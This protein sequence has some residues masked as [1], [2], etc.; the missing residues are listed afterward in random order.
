MT[1]ALD[2]DH[3]STILLVDDDPAFSRVM[4]RAL[5]RLGFN[6]WP[7]SNIEEATEAAVAVKPDFAVIDL[8]LGDQSGLDALEA[9]KKLSE[10]TEAIILSGY[11]N[12]NCA[13]T[14]TKLGAADC[15]PP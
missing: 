6:V 8:H 12:L 13:V 11:I 10:Q 15:L 3:E 9:I 2:S 1:V 4:A 7:A 5:G 14:A